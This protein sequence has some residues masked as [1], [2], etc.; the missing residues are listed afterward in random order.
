MTRSNK[1]A[2]AMAHVQTGAACLMAGVSFMALAAAPATAQ[3]AGD[4]DWYFFGDSNI[5]QGN[6]SAIVGSR[7]EDFYPNSSNNGFERD[8][9]GLIWAET[10]GRDVDVILDP[11]RDSPNLNFAISGAHM[12][13]GGDLLAF[14]IETGVQVQT[15]LFA[16]LVEAGDMSVASDDAFFMI[17]G[18]NDYLDRL[19]AGDSAAAITADVAAAAASNVEALASVGARTIVLSEIQPLQYAPQFADAPDVQA[20]LASMVDDANTAM[21]AAIEMED[22]PSDLNL[23]TMKYEAFMEHV[24]ANAQALG[25]SDTVTPCFDPDAETLCSTD[26]AIQNTHLWFDDLHMSE[27]GQRLVGQWWMATLNAANGNA[28]RQT[29][30]MPRVIHEQ[31]ETYRAQVRPGA[32]VE[33]GDGFAAYVTPVYAEADL[34]SNAGDPAASLEHD[35]AVLG[36]EWRFSNQ[37]IVGGALGVGETATRFDDGGRYKIG[38]GGLSLYGAFDFQDDGLLSLTMTRGGHEISGVTRITGVDLLAA[39]GETE[40]DYWDIELATR[41]VDQLGP[42]RIDHGLSLSAGSI[43]VDG[44]AETGAQGLAL[45]YEDQSLDTRR[46]AIDAQMSGPEFRVAQ[47]VRLTPLVDVAYAH[48]FGDNDYSVRSRLID[49]TANTVATRAMAPTED[50][51]GAAIGARLTLGE[52][53]SADLRY[54]RQWASDIEDARTG[55]LAV[56]F[57]Y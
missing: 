15:E 56:R 42:I 35:A 17:A 26:F 54:A 22:L 20:A 40:A 13:R 29:G 18:A 1:A 30:R 44:Y 57:T 50:R 49:N 24:V 11:D 52:R 4:G 23:V 9:N 28:G 31:V 16:A 36:M 47:A 43:K 10:L 32:H 6:F 14:G 51:L 38:G 8:S 53:W 33:S 21:F 34:K 2:R 25:V 3:S 19:D 41:C 46:F 27:R 55:S 12:T 39:S 37:F 45:S 48:Q 5:G 7:G